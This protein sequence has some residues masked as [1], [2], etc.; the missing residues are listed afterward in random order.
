MES[1]DLARLSSCR[2]TWSRMD[3]SLVDSFGRSLIL[4]LRSKLLAIQTDAVQR[5]IP[6]RDFGR[7]LGWKIQSAHMQRCRQW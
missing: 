7:V 6:I 5:T 1:F 3:C 4:S 2:S